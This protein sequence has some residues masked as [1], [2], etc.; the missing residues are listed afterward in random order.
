[1]ETSLSDL[2]KGR[3]GGA[4]VLSCFIFIKKSASTSDCGQFRFWSFVLCVSSN[5]HLLFLS[6]AV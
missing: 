2:I 5:Y 3:T 1:M 4:F 6:V